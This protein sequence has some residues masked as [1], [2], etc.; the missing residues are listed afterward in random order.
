MGFTLPN[1]FY[2]ILRNSQKPPWS[3]RKTGLNLMPH[4]KA[5][6]PFYFSKALNIHGPSADKKQ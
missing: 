4:F 6:L 1:Q 3:L 2:L 5:K